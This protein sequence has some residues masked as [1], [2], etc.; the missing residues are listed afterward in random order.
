VVTDVVTRLP[1]YDIPANVSVRRP[2]EVRS[3]QIHQS[4]GA[5]SL[6]A[7]RLANTPEEVSAMSN[8][9]DG[10]GRFAAYAADETG[11]FLDRRL[12]AQ[13][14]NSY[15]DERAWLRAATE[16]ETQ[17]AT[18]RA[19]APE[20]VSE[21]HGRR[22]R[23]FKPLRHVAAAGRRSWRPPPRGPRSRSPR[24]PSPPAPGSGHSQLRRGVLR[25]RLR[26]LLG[27]LDVAG[28]AQVRLQ[29]GQPGIPVGRL[30]PRVCD[31]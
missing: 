29:R 25:F 11:F 23:T 3:G 31:V 26:H 1:L 8:A 28:F 16:Y 2:H 18:F 4:A 30:A 9:I 13:T 19:E 15:G 21:I 17:L 12:Q 10:V 14:W 27:R 22:V 5:Q 7:A 6:A 24:G 20:V